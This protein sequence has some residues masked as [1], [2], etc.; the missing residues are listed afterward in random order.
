[1]WSFFQLK[2]QSSPTWPSVR[3]G[4]SW[5]LP[6]STIPS[7]WEIEGRR[8][9]DIPTAVIHANKVMKLAWSPDGRY[10]ASLDLGGTL[11]VRETASGQLH[12]RSV[13]YAFPDNHMPRAFAFDTDGGRVAFLHWTNSRWQVDHFDWKNGTITKRLPGPTENVYLEGAAFGPGLRLVAAAQL[14]G[15]VALWEPGTD[16]LRA[17]TVSLGRRPLRAVALSPDG[18]YVAVGDR[19]GVVSILRLS[20]RGQLPEIPTPPGAKEI[21]SSPGKP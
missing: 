7:V 15:A 10:L 3:T 5:P 12:R 18:R 2:A 6:A 14:G 17:K 13:G 21:E 19:A 16:P 1:M 11:I 9:K 8:A 20:E 4:G